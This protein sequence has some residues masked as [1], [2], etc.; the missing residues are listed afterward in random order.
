MFSEHSV[1]T[2][3]YKRH[4]MKWTDHDKNNWYFSLH[5][6]INYTI[7]CKYT[8]FLRHTAHWYLLPMAFQ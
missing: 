3:Q 7:Y 6:R 4:L 2:W 8:T 1:T 5:I